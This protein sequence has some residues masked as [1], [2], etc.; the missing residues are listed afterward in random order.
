MQPP[1]KLLVKILRENASAVILDLLEQILAARFL[2]P[3]VRRIPLPIKAQSLTGVSGVAMFILANLVNFATTPMLITIVLHRGRS[4]NMDLHG[5]R[6]GNII[7]LTHVLSPIPSG[8]VSWM[9]SP[10]GK[11]AKRLLSLKS[12]TLKR[13]E[14]NA[15]PHRILAILSP[16]LRPQKPNVLNPRVETDVTKKMKATRKEK[17]QTLTIVRVP[18]PSLL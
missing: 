16:L 13:E 7:S 6:K 5:K 8:K 10:Q 1:R 18:L 2:N 9:N 4:P 17:F 15:N 12:V 11:S 3:K 14:R